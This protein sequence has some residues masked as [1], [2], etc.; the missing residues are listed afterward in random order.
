[1]LKY[2]Y[3]AQKHG[4]L[5]A[6]DQGIR[7]VEDPTWCGNCTKAPFHGAGLDWCQGNLDTDHILY[8]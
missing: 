1:M 8:H 5:E 4:K 2:T 6:K 7:R 3:A